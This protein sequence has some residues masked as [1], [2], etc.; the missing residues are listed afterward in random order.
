MTM[1]LPHAAGRC[2][3]AVV[4]GLSLVGCVSLPDSSSVQRV[5]AV[6]V[7]TQ[8]PQIRYSP[9]GPQP[10]AA[11]TDIV[12]GYLQAMEAFPPAP[13]VVREYL[14]PSAASTWEPSQQLRVYDNPVATEGPAG[15]VSLTAEVLG[16]LDVRGSWVSA[17]P[18][19]N[20][21]DE[22]LKMA[23][24]DGEWRIETPPLGTL[25][26]EA[27][28][29]DDYHQYSLY[30]FDATRTILSPDPVFEL[31]GLHASATATALVRNLLLGP[32]LSMEGVVGSAV[33]TTTRLTGVVSVS[34]S[35]LADVPLTRE[36][37]SVSP[38]ALKLFAAQLAWTLQ[39]ERLGINHVRLTVAGRPVPVPG[40]GEVFPVDS[41]D[42]YDP[43][44]FSASRSL[45]ALSGG[46]LVTPTSSGVVAVP[47]PLGALSQS[48]QSAAIAPTGPL[49]ALV[50]NDRRTVV[51]GDYAGVTNVVG[52]AVWFE[53]GAELL[54]PSWDGRGLLWLVDRTAHGAVVHVVTKAGS[55]IVDAPGIAGQDVRAFAVSRDGSRFA[56]ILG[57]RDSSRLVIA[58]IRRSPTSVTD[59]G[60]SD[61][62]VVTNADFALVNLS[63]LAWYS[64][65]AVIVLA[66]TSGSEPQPYEI[67]IDGSHVQPTNGVLPIRPVSLAGGADPD[68]PPVIGSPDGKLYSRT[69]DQ[70][71]AL[72]PARQPLFAPAY[73][74]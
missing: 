37:R 45:Y 64:P 36:I 66:Q 53:G 24:V 44:I 14:T 59:V 55:R 61:P 43:S 12:K 8:P 3:V 60:L 74:G 33:P 57:R 58:M 1:R 42:G 39:Q 4:L 22:T 70:Q 34:A 17:T 25:L 31:L 26:D 67:A 19:D 10:G 56:A 6:G 48:A 16:S 63:Q 47:G 54:K 32:T 28:F 69:P 7:H 15:Y 50:T 11:P 27:T 2:A 13:A 21:L 72:I 38:T 9:R 29:S 18:S 51:V 41:F 68:V 71:W 49:G 40:F 30:Y 5:R 23:K 73:P 35:G 20:T 62:L 46:H 65:T 52:N